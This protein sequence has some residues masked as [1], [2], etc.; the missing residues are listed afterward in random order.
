MSLHEPD[1]RHDGF[2]LGSPSRRS[3]T[4]V[5]REGEAHH[6]SDGLELAPRLSRFDRAIIRALQE[7]GR[8]SFA[9]IAGE[10]QVPERS[11]SKRVHE[12]RTNGVIEITTVADP[13]LMGYGL[14]AIVGVRVD[15]REPISDVAARLAHVTGAFYV[16]VVTGRFNVLVELSCVD[17]DELLATVDA[18]ICGISGVT[19]IEILPYLRLHYQNPAFDAAT[20]KA[21]SASRDGHP[22]VRFDGVDR[23]IITRLHDDGRAPFQTIARELGVSESQVRT[24]VKR[25][26]ASEALRIMA[27]TVPRGV[28][29][30]TVALIGVSV[31]S[32]AEIERVAA[33]LAR[34]PSIIYVAICAGRFDILAEAVCTDREALLSLLDREV[35]RL[36]GI[37]RVEPWIY[38]QLHYRSVQPARAES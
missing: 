33:E 22:P 38:L 21:R 27:I 34:R 18:E 15:P 28:G 29:F 12:L 6:A 10:L 13:Q 35:R 11:V 31:G 19:A 26:V 7:D 9:R 1:H 14:I 20:R 4:P 3:I 24:R 17:T 16:I 30:E 32:G 25:M 5:D 2:E 23:E 8:R 36:P 37:A